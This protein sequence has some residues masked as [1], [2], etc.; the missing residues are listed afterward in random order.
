[1]VREEMEDQL[2]LIE[3]VQSRLEERSSRWISVLQ[4]T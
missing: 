3:K 4:D 1:M 2:Q